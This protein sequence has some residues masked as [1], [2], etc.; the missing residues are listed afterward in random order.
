M[1]SKFKKLAAA[2]SVATAPN[3]TLDH[4]ASGRGKSA[5]PS[6]GSRETDGSDILALIKT[7]VQTIR[8]EMK[9][10][11]EEDFNFIKG[12]LQAVRVEVG[13]SMVVLRAETDQVRMS[14]KIANDGLS[15][16]SDEVE[17][18]HGTVT[19]LK[20]EVD[21]LKRRFEAVE[22]HESPELCTPAD[23]AKMLTEVLRLSKPPLINRSHRTPGGRKSDDQ[24]KIAS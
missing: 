18:L 24:T 6:P 3:T 15:N 8:M 16:W 5:P 19:E 17:V 7:E 9:A 1:G 23:I 12:E 21:G 20:N 10:A 14:V 13:N 4:G 11:L 2:C 22:G